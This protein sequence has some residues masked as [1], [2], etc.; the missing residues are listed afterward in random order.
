M[1]A[2]IR[3]AEPRDVSEVTRLMYLAGKSNVE[4]SIYDLTFP[5]S[6]EERLEKLGSLFTAS[7]RSWYH[8]SFYLVNEVEGKV[9]G[10]LCGYNELEA[11]GAKLREA[12]IEIGIDRAEGMAMYERMQPFYRVNPIH[13]KD[14]WVI[15]HVAVFPEYCGQGL[16]YK[17]LNQILERG[18][19][20]GYKHAELGMLIGNTP[21]RKAYE[22]AGFVITDEYTDPDFEK[23]FGSPGMVRMVAK[24]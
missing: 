16:I 22:K 14:A 11:G 6:M 21:A 20:L 18:R 23:I 1:D 2:V 24:L 12:F 9:A 19:G 13:P 15:E 10:S 3:P 7:T 4:T 17:L 5:G 8:H